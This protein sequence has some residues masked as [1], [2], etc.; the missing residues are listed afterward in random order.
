MIMIP[1]NIQRAI[2]CKSLEKNGSTQ[3]KKMFEFQ[4]LN[5]KTKETG[6]IELKTN[7][8]SQTWIWT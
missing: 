3:P 2:C 1:E 6:E 8:K 4:N 7:T 5:P